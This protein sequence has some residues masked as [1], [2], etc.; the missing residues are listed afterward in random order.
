MEIYF[1]NSATTQISKE[2]IIKMDELNDFLYAN[3]SSMHFAGFKAE[4]KVKE[5]SIIL[6]NIINCEPSELIWTSGGTESNNLAIR[7]Y[8]NCY[9]KYGNKIIT[10]CIEHPSVHKVCESLQDEG[11]EIKYLNV[12]SDGHIDL[13]ELIDSI[14]DKVILVS[15]MYVNNE[16]GSKQDIDNIGKMIKKKNPKVAFHVDFV[17]GF[18][19]YKIDVKK[20][21][22]DFLS[23]SSHKFHGPKGV[24]VLYKNKMFRIKPII[25]GG[26][27]QNDFRAGTLNVPGIVGTAEAARL[28]Y[29]NLDREILRLNNLKDYLIDE[30]TNLNKKYDIISINS[31]KGDNFAPHIISVSF[32]NIRSEVMLH[33]LEEKGI[34]V[35]AGSACSSHNKKLSNTLLSIGLKKEIVECTIRISFGKYNTKEEVD[36]FISVLDELIPKL[37]IRRN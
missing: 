37:N 11:F 10:T 1:D 12:D 22:I 4:N 13:K 28:S 5:S 23:I 16:I 7:G 21:F 18:S 29:L 27:Q 20:S 32:K 14:D 19:K 31:K 2:V 30:L 3:P 17:Q 15:I 26:S 24:G 36:L 6:S 33:A 35:S 9:K 34:Y 25:I 8:A